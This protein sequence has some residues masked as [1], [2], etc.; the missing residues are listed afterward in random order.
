[1]TR[2]E[3][4]GG[5]PYMNAVELLDLSTV[6]LEQRYTRLDTRFGMQLRRCALFFTLLSLLCI[7]ASVLDWAEDRVDRWVYYAAGAIL[8]GLSV[9]C[10]SVAFA[11]AARMY[12]LHIQRWMCRKT[13]EGYNQA[14]P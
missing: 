2:K 14:S 5:L 8:L 6:E 9:Y 4:G 7:A 10:A 13:I 1:M 3:L 11:A 12:R